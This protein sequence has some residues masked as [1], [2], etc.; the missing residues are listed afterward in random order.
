M[1]LGNLE[2]FIREA[3]TALRRS[4]IMTLVSVGTITVS[5]VIFGAFLLAIVNMGNIVSSIGSKMEIMAYVDQ[6]LEDWKSDALKLEISHI[7]GVET[8]SFINKDEAWKNFRQ[9]FEGRLELEEITPNN[10]LPNVFLIK[11]SDVSKVS[12]IAKQISNI[13]IIDEVRYSGI[14]AQ[15]FQSFADAVRTGGLI[16][17]LL[18]GLAT[19]LIVVNTIR[20][21]VLARQTDI[22]IMRLVGATDSFVKGPFIIEG[23]FIG[24]V[25]SAFAFIIL[26]LSYDTLIFRLGEALPFL[27]L[28]TNQRLLFSIYIV[29]GVVGTLLGLS[30][31]YLSVSK[32]LKER[33]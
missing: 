23:I 30:G 2:F 13:A 28:V 20:L 7:S 14:L 33:V 8:V 5:L 10:P 3:W 32:S 31:G 1:N 25:G 21:T 17:V 27:P 18:L 29:V 26:K 11:V 24:L 12:E 15:R 9:D 6:D 22:A 16:L 19:F 4:A